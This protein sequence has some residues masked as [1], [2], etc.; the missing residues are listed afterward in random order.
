MAEVKG[1]TVRE[2]PADQG[3]WTVI[4]DW[5]QRVGYE[6]KDSG[7]WGRLYQKG[8]GFWNLPRML[9]ASPTAAGVRLEAWVRANDF[10]RLFAFFIVPRESILDSGGKVAIIPRNKGREEVNLLL[11]SL[12]QPLI[13]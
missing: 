8:T 9:L 12:G 6:L 7:E 10:N 5:A 11:Q 3:V 4:D 2:F 13:Q 1:R